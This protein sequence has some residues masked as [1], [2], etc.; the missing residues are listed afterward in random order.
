MLPG[1]FSCSWGAPFGRR[2]LDVDD[3]VERLLLDLDQLERVLGRVLALRHDGGDAGARERDAVDLERPRRVDEVLDAARLPRA[4]EGGQ[5][6]EV[7]AGEDGDNA[8]QRPPSSC[9]CS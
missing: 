5:V 8:G 6:L 2:L 9:R 3:D 7:L 1:A 4:R